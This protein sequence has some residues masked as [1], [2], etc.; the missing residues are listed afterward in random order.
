MDLGYAIAHWIAGDEGL[1]KDQQFD[2]LLP[3][4]FDILYC[5]V[6]CSALVHVHWC[7]MH[8]GRLELSWSHGP[9]GVG[10][11]GASERMKARKV[12]IEGSVNNSAYD[13]SRHAAGKIRVELR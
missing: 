1:W 2:V 6:N 9:K 13:S 4:I 3:S 10:L 5:F 11:Q 8:S 7:S 12:R